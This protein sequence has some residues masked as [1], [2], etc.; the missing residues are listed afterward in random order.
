M[1][2]SI[3]EEPLIHLSILIRNDDVMINEDDQAEGSRRSLQRVVDPPRKMN[4]LGK[5]D[6]SR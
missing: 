2:N 3:P 6:N 1:K 4:T 5:R